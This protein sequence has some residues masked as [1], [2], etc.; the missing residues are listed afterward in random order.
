MTQLA[1][2]FARPF[3]IPTSHWSW[4]KDGIVY[5]RTIGEHSIDLNWP[6]LQ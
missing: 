5:R 1:F 3:Y 2:S 6:W 4:R